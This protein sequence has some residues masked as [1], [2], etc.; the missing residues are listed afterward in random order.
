MSDPPEVHRRALPLMR[1]LR[2]RLAALRAGI[3]R[4]PARALDDL[5]R[6]PARGRRVLLWTIGI[7]VAATA[8]VTVI[9]TV[10]ALSSSASTADRLAAAGDVLVGATLLLAAIAAVVALLAYAVSTGTPDLQLQV[11]FIRSFPNNPVFAANTQDDG[12]LKAI[13]EYNGK[14]LVRN[15][16]GYSAKNPA[17]IVRLDAMFFKPYDATFFEGWASMETADTIQVTGQLDELTVVQWDGGPTYSIHGN[18]TRRLPDLQFSYLW[19][20]PEWGKPA[21]TFE[22]LAEGYRKVI[23]L[24]VDFTI[25]GKS[26]F[27]REDGK[28]NP[29]WM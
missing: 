15:D 8:V 6:D 26:Q 27:P 22:I 28:T 23:T 17:V 5:R 24:P 16:S 18:S 7:T 12:A 25:E 21:L 10:M 3:R 4:V 1:S 20:I 14:I 9:F 11:H 13:T 2:A 19:H 29:E